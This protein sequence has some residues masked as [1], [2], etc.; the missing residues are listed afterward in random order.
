MDNS[1]LPF[2]FNESDLESTKKKILSIKK[3]QF[4]QSCNDAFDALSLMDENKINLSDIQDA[5]FAL[6]RILGLFLD[7]EQ[8][9]KCSLI[10]RILNHHFPGNTSPLYEYRDIYK[11]T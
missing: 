6:R 8:Y 7:L 3:Q 2:S 11:N 1:D 5:N 10:Q 9:E 4:V